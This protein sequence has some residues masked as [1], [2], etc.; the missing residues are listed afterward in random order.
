MNPSDEP[1][2]AAYRPALF[3]VRTAELSPRLIR[4]QR[5]IPVNCE[6]IEVFLERL[7][8]ELSCS[9]FSICLI[10]DRAMRR[11]N[12]RFRHKNEATDVLSFPM[13]GGA[14]KPATGEDDYAGDI[15]ISVPTAQ[16]NA[17]RF[18]LRLE[19]E[20]KALI[21]HGL[22]H[23]LG[24]DHETDGGRMARSERRWGA[25]LGL[26]QTLLSRKPVVKKGTMLPAKLRSRYASRNGRSRNR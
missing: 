1:D 5:V 13:S 10:S 2:L 20:I 25:R 9:T 11:F 19:D 14:G 4:R 23:L 6:E 24:N 7:P 18:G 8:A 15:L 22:L 12:G 26:P 21:L 16:R 17:A 3:A